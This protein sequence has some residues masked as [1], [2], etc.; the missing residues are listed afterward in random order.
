MNK[1]LAIGILVLGV[2]M[3]S[4]FTPAVGQTLNP[5]KN[6]GVYIREN[7]DLSYSALD[8]ATNYESGGSG[9]NSMICETLYD[10]VGDSLTNLAPA[11]AAAQ[12]VVSTDGMQYNVTLKEGVMFTDGVEFNAWVYKYSIDRVLLVND[13]NSAGFLMAM[14][15]GAEDLISNGNLNASSTAVTDY[16]NAGG[17]KVLSDYEIQFNL[18]YA[19]SA[20]WPAMSYQVACAVSPLFVTSTIPAD[21]NTSSLDDTY[22]M[23]DLATWFPE[24]SGDYTKLGLSATHDS[25]NSGVVPS[26]PEGDDNQHDGYIDGQVGTGPWK[27]TTKTQEVIQLDRNMDWWA[28]DSSYG[29]D[30][31]EP[32]DVVDQ[33]LI[34]AVADPAT[35]ALSLKEGDADSVQIDPEFVDEFL[36][37]AGESKLPQVKAYKYDTLT[38]G[39]WGFNQADGDQLDAGA[40]TKSASSSAIWD[41]QTIMNASGLVGYN[42]LTNVDGSERH[43]NVTNP[44]TALNFR[45]A[46]AYSFDYDA[47]IDVALNGFATRLEGLIPVGLLGHQDDLI[48]IG[49]IPEYD[50]DTAKALFEEV[51]WEGNINIAFNSASA[52]RRAAANLLQSSIT[53]L[54]V[55][56]T[57]S[58]T[59]M[60]WSTFLL[61]YYTVPMF[62]LGWAPDFADPDNYMTPFVH[63]TKGYYSARISYY[64]TNWDTMLQA[65]TDETNPVARDA[66]YRTLEM[67]IANETIF[68]YTNQGQATTTMHYWWHGWENSGSEN[69]MR[70]FRRVHYMEKKPTALDDGSSSSSST[71]SSSVAP[72]TTSSVAPTSTSDAPAASSPGFEIFALL[73]SLVTVGIVARRRRK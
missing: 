17:V 23:I 15:A 71:P 29:S 19:Y 47:Y 1:K 3:V 11:L 56:I 45:K 8:P 54:D 70:N 30:Y 37:P 41:N 42:H 72:T 24:L 61:R 25:K 16:F 21:Y 22:G 39:F 33:I 59:E 65:A 66:L 43:P 44:F 48:D 7:H 13:H 12:P 36:T 20:F 10:Y 26:A 52:A 34:K 40:I 63:S 6:P 2:F 60:L 31:V 49:L 55:G 28:L 51:G 68:M 58:V 73:A 9:L 4:A 53:A 69:P 32:A 64:N 46:F 27:L 57:I 35:R 62:L 18:D 5:V 14:L 38:I 67:Q 50:P